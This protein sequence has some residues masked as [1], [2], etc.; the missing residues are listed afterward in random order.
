MDHISYND[1]IRKL[2]KHTRK[3]LHMSQE[4]LAE[5]TNMS[6]SKLC[7]IENGRV[8]S[9]IL[10]DVATIAREL[11][12]SMHVIADIFDGANVVPSK[13][14]VKSKIINILE[15]VIDLLDSIDIDF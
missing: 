8:D 14:Q 15:F 5:R 1:R 13:G 10:N 11:S 9:L 3:K 4:T 7:D 6:R 2:I 12:I